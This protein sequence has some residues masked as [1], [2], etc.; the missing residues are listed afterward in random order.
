MHL[1]RL[2]FILA[3]I[4]P[5]TTTTAQAKAAAGQYCKAKIFKYACKPGCY[6]IGSDNCVAW[7]PGD[8][9][10]GCTNRWAKVTSELNSKG[11]Y[12]C[13]ADFPQSAEGA[14]SADG[15]YFLNDQNSKV[16]N[17]NVT[18][19]AGTYLPAKSQDCYDCPDNH[20]CPG[21]NSVKPSK[22]ADQGKNACP[23]NKITD[24]KGATSESSCKNRPP[25][26]C[27][28]GYY[29]E[30]GVDC[31]ECPGG[32]YCE[33]GTKGKTACPAAIPD[34]YRNESTY[35]ENY[36]ASDGEGSVVIR[37]NS[38]IPKWDSLT[39]KSKK[40][41]CR[42]VYSFT[43]KRSDWAADESTTWNE[44]TKAYDLG[45]N[46]YYVTCKP[47]FYMSE[48]YTS[49]YCDIKTFD[50]GTKKSMLYK[51]VIACPP[52]KYCPGVKQ[53]HCDSGTYNDT[54][55]LLDP[56][57]VTC[58]KDYYLPANTETCDKCPGGKVCPGGD[59]YTSHK[60][61]GALTTYTQQ[62]LKKC[63]QA[64]DPIAFKQC[65]NGETTTENN[66]K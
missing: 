41:E 20:Y 26:S 35:P 22:S 43:N 47:G 38:Y 11:V 4:W 40:T 62:E 9:K 12:L 57:K 17:K 51:K 10:G 8:V 19:K 58:A 14:S 45:G 65:M 1:L 31:I 32:Y 13:P 36:Y 24:G 29:S 44:S 48:K 53:T 42:M 33:G 15:C 55:G 25:K 18:C 6:C 5:A 59:Y 46:P 7:W 39:K 54:I 37:N 64:I 50:D 3:L 49:T 61:Q 28:A 56:V 60:P 27:N 30:N 34:H 2:F 21:V 52:D 66:N 23:N 16:Y 63:W